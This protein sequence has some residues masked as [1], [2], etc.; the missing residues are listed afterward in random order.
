MTLS[1][2]PQVIMEESWKLKSFFSE[3]WSKDVKKDTLSG[4]HQNDNKLSRNE[5]SLGG[6]TKN[7]SQIFEMSGEILLRGLIT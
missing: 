5:S 3:S 6:T 2:V 1:N 4:S 7:R